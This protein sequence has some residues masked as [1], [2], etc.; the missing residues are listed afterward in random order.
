MN[1]T[2]LSVIFINLIL[3]SMQ[4]TDTPDKPSEPLFEQLPA[5]ETRVDFENNL[6][7]SEEFNMYIFRN[8]YNG[9]GVALGDVSGNGLP[10]LFLTGNRVSNRL[11]LNKGD[12]MFEDVTDQAGLGS[13]GTWTTGASMV[14]INGDGR[15]DIYIT[16]SGPPSPSS[17]EGV[18]HNQLFI[19]NGDLTFTDRSEEFGLDEMGLSTHAVF[20]DYDGDGDLDMY[21]LN[22]SFKPVGGYEGITGEAR[23]LTDPEGGSKL[24]RNNGD[25]FEDVSREAGIYGSR[26][27]FDLSATVADL[28][29]DGLPD[30]YVANDFFERDYL[31]MNNGDGTF[32]EV[33]EDR[34]NT[35][36]SS[37]MGADITDLTNN[38]WPD[39]YV[40]DMLPADEKRQ[41]SKMEYPTYQEYRESLDHGFHHQITRN[42]L[43]L[44]N[45]DGTFSEVGRLAGVEA[46]DWSWA[47]L[48][49]DF[50]H[51]G[52]QDIFV[53][54]GIYKDLLDQ[55]YIE[56]TADPRRVM[57][58]QSSSSDEVIMSLMEM[59][60]SQAVGNFMFA[61]QG[62][63]EFADRSRRWGL[64]EPG[65][66]SGAAWADLDGDGAL[67]LV[68]NQVNGP[69]RIYRNHTATR[70]PDRSWLRVSLDG[71]AP[72][73]QAVGAQLEVWAGPNRYYREHRLQRGFQ[74][75]MAPGL[76]VGL[77]EISRIDS[78]RL[79]WPDG[80]ISRMRDVDVPAHLHLSQ[81]EAGPAE[82]V[83]PPSPARVA[84]D[85]LPPEVPLLEEIT[86][87]SGLDWA[88]REN[89][90]VDFDRERL[91]VHMRSTEGPALCSGDV[92]GN[93]LED[94]YLGGARDQP[95]V[96][97]IH[98]PEGG[99]V[100]RD[101]PAV[102]ADSAS[103]D[104][105]CVFFDA[106]GDGY[107]D[108]YVTSGGNSYSSGSS[109]LLDRLYWGDGQGGFAR[110]DQLL[111]SSQRFATTSTVAVE[112]FT[113]DGHPDLFVGERLQLFAVGLPARGMLLANDGTG[114]FT[115]VS[116]A[117]APEL[118]GLGMVTDAEWTDWT[119]DGRRE[120]VVVGEWMAPR[121]FRNTGGRLQEITAEWGLEELTGWW[122]RVHAAD[123]NGDGRMDLVLA[124][125]GLNSRFRASAGQPVR[126]WV[127]DFEGNGMVDQMLSMPR[128]GKD[129]PVALRHDLLEGVP[130]LREKYP[131]YASYAGQ[132]VQQILGPERLSAARQLQAREL[133]SV[134]VW[135]EADG[136][137]VGR[138]PLRAQLAPMY[139]I[140]S[141]DLTG[142]G[143]RELL[144][145]GNLYE[146]KPLAG[147]Y[148]ASRGVVAGVDEQG[149]VF[150]LPPA[151]SGFRVDGAVRR[152]TGLQDSRGRTLIV[153]ARNNDSPKVFR[154]RDEAGMTIQK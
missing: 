52:F 27:G 123:L 21:L 10:D 113:G 147:P 146:V 96:L 130:S 14:D 1:R 85:E 44:N 110:S 40:A 153:V 109:A 142:D 149:G 30:L 111:P 58:H 7:P 93:G 49:A 39:I 55:D 57:S 132:T 98:R 124:N 86:A 73:T 103:E 79:R 29:R 94:I 138:L 51:S 3:V 67:D 38:G 53:T 112:D 129:Y 34:M 42:T 122:N 92:T 117:W 120:L 4:C 47:V 141:G 22:N 95:G 148:D 83:R 69:V 127:G 62:E 5:S 90:Y 41:K 37:S 17:E 16:K 89:E 114:T 59:I 104:T 151:G 152:I 145:G 18:R 139:G 65:F 15:L 12:F 48:M 78:L 19:N 35:I 97:F 125:H 137:R 68:I 60:P 128:E 50:D 88:H 99:F 131:D 54:N 119:G 46:T 74:S 23:Q 64:D 100:M 105:D 91:L 134:I 31:Y 154:V 8:F 150:T 2:L 115:D 135:N 66:S 56:Y 61:G 82:P 102:A 87:R 20:F 28:N 107:L 133:G 43:Q 63:L 25:H 101:L 77:E 80:R 24:F 32:R 13:Q 71:Q 106:N 121:V 116:E 108:L 75:S 140:W 76:H 11:Y 81:S 70:H 26:I 118:A 36:S 45:G 126:M 9:G 144:M 33:L 84:G 136:V 72:N 6:T 143:R